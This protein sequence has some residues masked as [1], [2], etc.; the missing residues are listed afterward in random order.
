[1]SVA[2]ITLWAI[3]IVAL[4]AYAVWA[5]RAPR[6]QAGPGGPGGTPFPLDTLAAISGPLRVHTA[7]GERVLRPRAGARHR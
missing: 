7:Q 6:A 3:S 1:M 2:V 5:N 4:A